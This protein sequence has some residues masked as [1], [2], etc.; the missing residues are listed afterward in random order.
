MVVG[1]AI[2]NFVTIIFKKH[3]QGHTTL[4]NYRLLE[5]IIPCCLLGSILGV[6]TESLTPKIAQ[7]IILVVVFSYFTFT[8]TQK[9]RNLIRTAKV[10]PL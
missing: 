4:V 10:N 9:L 6:I 3:P 7:L 5:L 1:A 2:P 8:F